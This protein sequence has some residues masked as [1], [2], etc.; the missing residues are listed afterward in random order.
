MGLFE[1]LG[2][3]GKVKSI[4]WDITP[5]YTFAMFESWGG[6]GPE[7][8]RNNEERFYYFFIDNWQ[9]PAKLCLMERGVKHA[10]VLA[11]IDAPQELID[12]CITEQG[13]SFSLDRS[14][15]VNNEL[16]RWL[17]DNVLDAADDSKIIPVA[18]PQAPAKR[19]TKLPPAA[20]APKDL[21]PVS[22]RRAGMAVTEE[23]LPQMIKKRNFFDTQ[24]NPGGSF[25]NYLVE[26]GDSATL[27]DLATSLM[28]QRGGCDIT[29]IRQVRK[30]VEQLNDQRF[31]GHD[32]WR[33]PTLEEALSLLEPQQNDKGLYLHPSFSREQPFIFLS[34]WREP[35]G[36]WFMDFKQGTPFWASGTIPG[37]FGRVCR[38]L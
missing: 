27:I 33:L 18:S 10:Q 15:A 24:H 32:D 7:R 37:G 2:L 25:T 38:S 36:Y 26:S 4:D 20:S 5:A 16:K 29:A 34:D 31:G 28:W 14:Y 35:G 12:R 9:E 23:E 17:I 30:Y 19:E 8:I 22:L 3:E 13:K 21:V 1:K 11:Y 6:K